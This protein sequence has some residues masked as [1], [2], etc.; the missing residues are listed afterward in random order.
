MLHENRYIA[1]HFN[2]QAGCLSVRQINPKTGKLTGLLDLKEE[3]WLADADFTVDDKKWRKWKDG[4]AQW[5]AGN[6][7]KPKQRQF[8]E[9]RGRFL[10]SDPG[11]SAESLQ[12]IFYDPH[13]CRDFHSEEGRKIVT[14]KFVHISGRAMRAVL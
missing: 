1:V 10:K 6:G 14:A 5:K 11:V 4:I 2:F 8:A 9:I 13:C 3:V 7:H 12:D